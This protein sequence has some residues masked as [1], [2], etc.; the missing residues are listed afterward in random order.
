MARRK[1][2]RQLVRDLT[3]CIDTILM[4]AGDPV[5]PSMMR[6]FHMTPEVYA[7]V[8]DHATRG[9]ALLDWK[10]KIYAPM[11]QPLPEGTTH[12]NAPPVLVDR[13]ERDEPAP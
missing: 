4:Y 1:E 3:D 9:H 13:V 7:W 12:E 5:R 11:P 10:H 8:R 2:Y 6:V